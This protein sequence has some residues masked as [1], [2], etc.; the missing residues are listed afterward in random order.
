MKDFDGRDVTIHALY[1]KSYSSPDLEKLTG[2]MYWNFLE[3]EFDPDAEDPEIR[4]L[5][6]NLVDPPDA[7]PR[8]GGVVSD[9]ASNT[10]RVASSI[11]PDVEL[12]SNADVHIALL[13]GQSRRGTRTDANGRLRQRSLVDVPPDTPVLITANNGNDAD[14]K[15]V[16][17]ESV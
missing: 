2:P 12:L 4:L 1:H 5:I 15:V 8:G 7:G 10:G 6:R 16:R 13:N 14:A 3:M 9:S 17:T 11:V